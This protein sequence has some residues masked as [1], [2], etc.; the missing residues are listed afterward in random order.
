MK[1]ELS[2]SEMK[3]LYKVAKGT[4]FL[5]LY[6]KLQD[7]FTEDEIRELNAILSIIY[8]KYWCLYDSAFESDIYIVKE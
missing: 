7:K 6:D 8:N 5:Y 3:L 4:N 2:E 1:F